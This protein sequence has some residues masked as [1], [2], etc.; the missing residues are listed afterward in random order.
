MILVEVLY[1][2]PC[3]PMVRKRGLLL[4]PWFCLVS[5][6]ELG[7][8]SFLPCGSD[9]VSGRAVSAEVKILG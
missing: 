2:K 5:L 4:P 1:H 6:K 9:T 7:A 8:I 3:G